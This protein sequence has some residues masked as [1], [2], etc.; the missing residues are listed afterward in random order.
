MPKKAKPDDVRKDAAG[1]SGADG[2]DRAAVRGDGGLDAGGLPD[3]AGHVSV[4]ERQVGKTGKLARSNS[5]RAKDDVRRAAAKSAGSTAQEQGGEASGE[6]I[7]R[8]IFPCPKSMAARI[9]AERF[10][11]KLGS[12]SATIRVL[13]TEALGAGK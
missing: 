13:L 12:K 8:L 2:V 7:V 9:E 11:R 3:G 1:S 4:G 5:G 6:E 10:R